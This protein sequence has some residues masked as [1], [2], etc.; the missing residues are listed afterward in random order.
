M[1]SGGMSEEG[2]LAKVPVTVGSVTPLL[3]KPLARALDAL[4]GCPEL[5]VLSVPTT[6]WGL[7]GSSG[8][9]CSPVLSP[10]LYPQNHTGPAS[11]TEAS[12]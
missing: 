12:A 10:V 11:K 8:F 7:S 9:F 1:K 6:Q 5:G 2:S 3:R 4:T